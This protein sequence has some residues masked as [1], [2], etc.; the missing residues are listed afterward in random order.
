MILNQTYPSLQFDRPFFYL[1][2][3]SFQPKH[4]ILADFIQLTENFISYFLN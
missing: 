3:A 2:F 4:A 1:T